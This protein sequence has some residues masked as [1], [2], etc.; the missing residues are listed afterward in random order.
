MVAVKKPDLD[1]DLHF[2]RI[3]EFALLT[4][5]GEVA[6]AKR[7]ERTDLAITRRLLGS[8][9]GRTA[10]HEV[11]RGLRE[12]ELRVEEVERNPS[13]AQ[14]EGVSLEDR[15]EGLIARAHRRSKKLR[16]N[17]R[18][19]G[20][21]LHPR[22]V[23]RLAQEIPAIDG[24]RREADAIT[25]D[26]VH[27]NLR[28]VV[29]FARRYRGMPLVDLVQEG[30]FGLLR[31]IDKFDH[32]RGLRF[33]TYAAWWI[34]HALTRALADQSRMIRL[35]VHLTGAVLRVRRAQDRL[36][37]ETGIT[38]T[39]EE[40]AARTG[41][42][43][44][45]VRRALDVVAQPVSLDAMVGD[46]KDT[47][48]GDLVADTSQITADEALANTQLEEGTRALLS[49]LSDREAEV[50]RLR[51]GVGGR[52][53]RTLEEIGA[54]LSVSRER[55]R[56]IERDALRKLRQASEAQRLRLQLEG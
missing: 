9:E 5:E 24:L 15:L 44:A 42:P 46:E 52:A 19:E 36:M 33:S 48:L 29:T 55:A 34:R 39:P 12:K 14:E 1:L 49:T 38:P 25:A 53:L 17:P 8:L 43:I 28:I 32:R 21:R 35:P 41:L 27:A 51:F 31:A 47:E 7:L 56:Q 18:A 2:Q 30:N 37:R 16:W 40:L 23:A 13:A 22:I 10:L 45:N 54:R 11:V 4:H 50:I 26:F 6:L 3:N 20:L